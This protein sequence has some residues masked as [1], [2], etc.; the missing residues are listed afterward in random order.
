MKIF[1]L[2]LFFFADWTAYSVSSSF[3][4]SMVYGGEWS[5]HKHSLNGALARLDW[6]E[7]SL[8]TA[9]IEKKTVKDPVQMDL[10]L[11][12]MVADESERKAL[13][14]KYSKERHHA[15]FEHPEQGAIVKTE[16]RTFRFKPLE[17][18]V[19]QGGV[20]ERLDLAR[21]KMQLYFG[22]VTDPAADGNKKNEIT[23]PKNSDIESLTLKK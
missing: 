18:I 1:V 7:R 8:K 17:E 16:Y 19:E 2:A 13:Y 4:I 21:T 14:E 6:L 5:A 9:S 15:Q 11:K 22:K 12:R 23:K 10:L 20:D 3:T